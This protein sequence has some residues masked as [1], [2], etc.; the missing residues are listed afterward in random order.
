[1]TEALILDMN[2]ELEARIY[3][4]FGSFLR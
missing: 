4:V 3:E 1:M 2:R